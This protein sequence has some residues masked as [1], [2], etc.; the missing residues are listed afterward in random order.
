MIEMVN[1]D[2]RQENAAAPHAKCH[3]RRACYVVHQLLRFYRGSFRSTQCES[4][5]LGFAKFRLSIEQEHNENTW[6]SYQMIQNTNEGG[7]M[8]LYPRRGRFA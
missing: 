1:F 4:A 2:C 5:S 3:R 6:S 7:S 8:S